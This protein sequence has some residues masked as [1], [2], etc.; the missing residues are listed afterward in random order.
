MKIDKQ[1]GT[2]VT[3]ASGQSPE[4]AIAV[5]DSYVYWIDGGGALARV[6]LAGGAPEVIAT[7]SEQGFTQ[8]MAVNSTHVYWVFYRYTGTTADGGLL[9]APIEGGAV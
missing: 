2:P 3:L 8:Q 9:R 5:D 7:T 4:E 6:P 1:G